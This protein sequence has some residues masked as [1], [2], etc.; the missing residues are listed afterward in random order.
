MVLHVF[1][2]NC[3]LHKVHKSCPGADLLYPSDFENAP[4]FTML[5][6]HELLFYA[7]SDFLCHCFAPSCTFN[8]ARC[9]I[10]LLLCTHTVGTSLRKKIHNAIPKGSKNVSPK[11]RWKDGSKLVCLIH[12]KRPNS[13]QM[14]PF[15]LKSLQW[16]LILHSRALGR[17]YF[18]I[19]TPGSPTNT[20]VIS[21]L[22]LI[23]YFL[24]NLQKIN[25]SMT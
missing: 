9:W 20:S 25:C 5:N 8:K 15:R 24:E 16:A 7:K 18:T 19:I 2:S 21:D 6:V 22:V 4:P 3:Q 13:N 1:S 11:G 14:W 10:W 17:K 12:Y 23:Q